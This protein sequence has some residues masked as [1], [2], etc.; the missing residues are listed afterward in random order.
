MQIMTAIIG[1]AAGLAA[2]VAAGF[3]LSKT[4]GA[5]HLENAKLRAETILKEAVQE[6]EQRKREKLTEAREESYKLRQELEGR[7]KS[8]DRSCRE[9]NGDSNKKKRTSIRKLTV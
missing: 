6:G 5:K 2:G 9:Q 3:M 1:I 4:I 7:T 8:A